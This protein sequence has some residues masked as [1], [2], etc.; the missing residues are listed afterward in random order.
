L[1]TGKLTFRGEAEEFREQ[2]DPFFFSL[3]KILKGFCDP[4]TGPKSVNCFNIPDFQELFATA[5]IA[6]SCA[7][8]GEFPLSVF[9]DPSFTITNGDKKMVDL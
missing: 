7:V 8:I 2:A 1:S 4:K 9:P 5:A 3:T 6:A